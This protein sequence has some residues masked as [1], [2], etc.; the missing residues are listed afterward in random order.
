MRSNPGFEYKIGY[1]SGKVGCAQT[2][3]NPNIKYGLV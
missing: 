3:E 2:V 1:E